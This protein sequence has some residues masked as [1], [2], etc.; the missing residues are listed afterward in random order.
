MNVARPLAQDFHPDR[1]LARD[2]IGI[3][4]RV[5][6]YQA[7]F[8]LEQQRAFMCLVIVITVQHYLAPQVHYRLHLDVRRGLRHDD[9]GGCAALARRECH[10]LRV[11]PGRSADNAAL[12]RSLRQVRDLVVRTAQ[13][14]GEHGLQILALEQHAIA[15]AARQT[16]RGL[17]RRFDRH[18]V[19]PRLENLLDVVVV[20]AIATHPA[21]RLR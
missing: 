19:D 17:E 14:E 1:A 12:R 13:L 20:H 3:V 18:I 6:E 15:Q 7:A 10:T 4:E 2:H 8:A 16:F 5:N 9:D 21:R 11:V